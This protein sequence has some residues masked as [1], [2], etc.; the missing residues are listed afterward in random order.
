MRHA[1]TSAEILVEARAHL[2][3]LRWMCA[4]TQ[5]AG[6]GPEGREAAA[7]W[8]ERVARLEPAADPTWTERWVRGVLVEEGFTGG[9]PRWRSYQADSAWRPVTVGPRGQGVATGSPQPVRSGR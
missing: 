8:L 5:A 4:L 1:L 3:T 9:W 6:G 7:R 2:A